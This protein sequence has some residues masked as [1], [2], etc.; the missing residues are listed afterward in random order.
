MSAAGPATGG[1]AVVSEHRLR[2]HAVAVRFIA[3]GSRVEIE[4]RRKGFCGRRR[5]RAGA[6]GREVTPRSHRKNCMQRV[7]RR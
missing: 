1:T 3:Q 7:E 5:C 4:S 6:P 2:N